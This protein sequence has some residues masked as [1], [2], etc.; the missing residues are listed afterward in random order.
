MQILSFLIFLAD[1][2]EQQRVAPCTDTPQSPGKF[3]VYFSPLLPW[4]HYTPGET[5]G[6][7]ALLRWKSSRSAS[8]LK[9]QKH[10]QEQ[11]VTKALRNM[12]KA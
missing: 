5:E 7:C 9:I 3:H 6:S 10:I 2:H 1:T 4:K 8:Q 12:N 11:D